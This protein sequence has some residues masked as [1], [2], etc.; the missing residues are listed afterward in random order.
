M[1]HLICRVSSFKIVG[2]YTLKVG[3]DDNTEQL[4]DFQPVLAGE[5]YSPLRS[6]ELFKQVQ[7]DS[8]TGTLV[9]PN[10]AD[11]DSATLHDWPVYK[12]AFLELTARWEP[13]PF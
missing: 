13:V 4:I 6:V 8:E 2:P 5:L 7:I 9:W 1:S 12:Q 11:F 10:G 3:F